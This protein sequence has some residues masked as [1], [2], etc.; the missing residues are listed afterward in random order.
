MTAVMMAP[1]VVPWLRA[2]K[3]QASHLDTPSFVVSFAAGY[4]IAW[5]GFS[6]AAAG[7]QLALAA[8]EVPFPSGSTRRTIRPPR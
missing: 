5:A 4:G 8:F 2:L 3:R 6:A 7:I 1:I